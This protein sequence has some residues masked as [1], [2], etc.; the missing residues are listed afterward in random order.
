MLA[1]YINC[2]SRFL[3]LS[4]VIIGKVLGYRR[5]TDYKKTPPNKN[6]HRYYARNETYLLASRFIYVVI[7]H[8]I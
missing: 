7:T 6:G 5:Q 4:E 2:G 8:V 3:E 1:E